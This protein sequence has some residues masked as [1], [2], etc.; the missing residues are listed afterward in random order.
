MV[1]APATLLTLTSLLANILFVVLGLSISNPLVIRA[2]ARAFGGCLLSI[3]LSL[4]AFGARHADCGAEADILQ[5][6]KTDP[7]SVYLPC[8][9]FHLYSHAVVA[10]RKNVTWKQIPHTILCTAI[11]YAARQEEENKC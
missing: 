4:F 6:G 8:I 9:Y 2:A 5:Q 7:V 11:R 1:I 3:Y 10:L